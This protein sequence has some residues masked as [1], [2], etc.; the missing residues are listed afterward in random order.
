MKSRKFVSEFIERHDVLVPLMAAKGWDARSG[1]LE[2]ESSAY[3][4]VAEKWV[5][6]VSP[7]KKAMPSMQEAY[8][9]FMGIL[10][11]SQDKKTGFVK[12]A[13]EYY[14]PTIAKQWVDWLVEDINLTIMRRDVAEAEQ[15]IVYL[16]DQIESTSLAELQNVFFSLVEEQT[17]TVMLARVSN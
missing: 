11:V 15:A 17:K 3:D 16:N 4:V 8:E 5:R 9:K 13:V 7:P 2:I 14:S 10:S 6:E 1:E 12:V